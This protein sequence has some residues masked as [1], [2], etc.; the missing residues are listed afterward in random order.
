MKKTIMTLV[1]AAL[2]LTS[3]ATQENGGNTKQTDGSD[4][5]PVSQIWDGYEE[6]QGRQYGTAFMLPEKI[7]PVSVEE[8]DSFVPED[9]TGRNDEEDAKAYFKAFFGDEYNEENVSKRDETNYFYL[10]TKGVEE[11][12]SA[13][14]INGCPLNAQKKG[15]FMLGSNGYELKQ[16]YYP[17]TDG[18]VMLEVGTENLTVSEMF[19]IAVRYSG[20]LLKGHYTELEMFPVSLYTA[21]SSDLD[22]YGVGVIMGFKYK[23]LAIEDHFT[24]LFDAQERGFYEVITTY[25]PI[26]FSIDFYGSDDVRFVNYTCGDWNLVAEPQENVI[27]LK[28]AVGLLEKELATNSEYKFSNVSLIYCRKMTGPTR[29]EDEKATESIL[30]DYGESVPCPYVPTWVFSFG[31]DTVNGMRENYIKVN[32]LT[33][34]ITVDI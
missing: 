2:M 18:D 12:N 23:G 1:L 27:S 25:D 5:V 14:Y 10:E 3:C 30:A 13:S 34:E 9:R 17:D 24:N 19:D 6:L 15:S 16:R 11:Y 29:G 4:K 32:A 21:Y 31:E 8:L 33:G 26:C 7:E 20:D 28:A 22:D